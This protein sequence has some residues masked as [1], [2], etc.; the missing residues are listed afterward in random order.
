[1]KRRNHTVFIL[2][3]ISGLFSLTGCST[4]APV[5]PEARRFSYTLSRYPETP[6]PLKIKKLTGTSFTALPKS[7]APDVFIVVHP[8]Y[9][10]FFRD[11]HR[12][13][14]SEA[15][16]ALLLLQLETEA[17]FIKEAS[18]A[19]KIV[20][21]VVPGSY[22]TES[23]APR[24]YTSYLNSVAGAGEKTFILYSETA[25]SGSIS[26]NDMIDLYRFLDGVKAGKVLI[27]GGYIGRCQRE[28]YVGLTGYFDKAPVY[29][30]PELSTLSPD[31]ITDQ[32][33]GKV[34][35]GIRQQDYRAVRAF[36]NKKLDNPKLLSI[37]QKKE[38]TL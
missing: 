18:Q 37:P 4:G 19:G 9:S 33:A 7:P 20:I 25:S 26:M 24:S 16:Y 23:V 3:F 11:E 1:M 8:A 2:I 15:K 5:L 35:E 28:F 38:Q 36:I 17:N 12:S 14:Y 21:L 22:E 29:V 13:L 6:D 32:E 10:L 27:G 31:D 30:V 34:L